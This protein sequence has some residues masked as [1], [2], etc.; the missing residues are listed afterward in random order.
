VKTCEC[1][2]GEELRSEEKEPPVMGSTWPAASPT[3][4]RMTNK[5]NGREANREKYHEEMICIALRNAADAERSGM[6]WRKY[7]V[8]ACSDVS[9][10]S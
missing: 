5:Y 9:D 7:R 8:I 6:N 10:R 4:R 3:C 1:V 2:Q